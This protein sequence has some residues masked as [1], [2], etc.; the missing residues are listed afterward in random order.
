MFNVLFAY[1]II[2]NFYK[3]SFCGSRP[4]LCAV[5]FTALLLF[6]SSNLTIS[7]FLSTLSV[8]M[9]L[10]LLPL[11]STGVCRVLCVLSL[12]HP[13]LSVAPVTSIHLWSPA[14]GSCLHA[15]TLT[16]PPQHTHLPSAP[17]MQLLSLRACPHIPTEL[18][19]HTKWQT[20]TVT[21][22]LRTC[23]LRVACARR[24]RR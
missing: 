14:H 20:H 16:H 10:P 24:M 11:C 12:Q 15:H 18:V 19:T 6:N 1:E 21:H 5:L 4:C 23:N 2:V 7:L 13:Q 8:L 9:C 22:A 3:I 17:N